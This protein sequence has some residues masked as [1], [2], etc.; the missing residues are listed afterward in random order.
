MDNKFL[1]ISGRPGS[2]KTDLMI[3]Y[4]NQYPET[5]L[6]L[7]EESTK[8]QLQKKGLK[9]TV[10]VVGKKKFININVNK[11]DAVCIDY[12]ELF[13]NN[14]IKNYIE[15]LKNTDIRMI[16]IDQM[17]GDGSVHHNIFV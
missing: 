5:T 10:K 4:A 12:I 2:G 6:I 3:H 9:E 13:D 7:S 17:R 1:L 16:V 11:Y 15:P 14:F 8:K